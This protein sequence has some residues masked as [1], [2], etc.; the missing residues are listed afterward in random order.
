MYKKKVRFQ[1]VASDRRDIM[2]YAIDKWKGSQ[3]GQQKAESL[4]DIVLRK[5]C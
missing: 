1:D 5:G 3:T 2:D 4:R